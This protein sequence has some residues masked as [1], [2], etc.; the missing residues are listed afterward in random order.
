[1]TRFGAGLPVA[2]A[3]KTLNSM[4]L[5]VYVCVVVDVQPPAQT[6]CALSLSF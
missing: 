2:Y 3:A 1:M 5:L 4:V 6:V